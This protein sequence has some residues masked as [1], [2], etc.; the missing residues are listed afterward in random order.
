MT[1]S[2]AMKKNMGM[3]NFF[4]NVILWMIHEE[5]DEDIVNVFIFFVDFVLLLFE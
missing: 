1:Y 3:Y 5:G 2:S 4:W